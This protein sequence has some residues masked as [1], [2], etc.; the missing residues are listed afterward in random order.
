MWN[1]KNVPGGHGYHFDEGFIPA[2]FQGRCGENKI[3]VGM[4]LVISG[5]LALPFEMR[6]SYIETLSREKAGD[7]AKWRSGDKKSHNET[8]LKTKHNADYRF[9]E[10]RSHSN[11][12]DNS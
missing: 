9:S 7:V 1:A 11:Y 10:S 2:Q 5:G 8:C 3:Y 12:S 6:M 4:A